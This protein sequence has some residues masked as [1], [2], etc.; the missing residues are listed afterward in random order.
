[1]DIVGKKFN[2]LKV[3]EEVERRNYQPYVR[4]ICDCG[5]EV[6]TRR[7]SVTSG[8]TKSCGCY[9]IDIMRERMKTA[10]YTHGMYGT[11]TYRTYFMMKDRC[12]NKNT[13]AY[14]N[15]GDRE[16]SICDRWLV[17][18]ENFLE[19]MGE[20]PEGRTLDRENNDGNYEPGNCRWATAAEQG[21][22]TRRNHM[23]E[24]YGSRKSLAEWSRVLNIPSATLRT[25]LGRQGWSVLKTLTTPIRRV[26]Q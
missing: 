23:I 4:C 13:P 17:S 20:R 6:T 26:A 22:N 21:G 1:M 3:L 12:L 7:Y 2:R 8:R 10:T 18:F 14:K 15:Y 9:N 25:R 16:I 19:D 11:R 24:F 5:K